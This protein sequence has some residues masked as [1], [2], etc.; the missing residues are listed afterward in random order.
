MIRFFIAILFNFKRGPSIVPAMRKMI[1]HKDKYPEK[2]RYALALRLIRYL[3]KSARITT[4]VYGTENLP[5]SGG[6][7]MYPNHQGKY[8]AL[9]IMYAHR[10]PCTFVMDKAK[11][12]GFLVREMVDLLGAKRL[13]L[14]DVRQNIRIMDQIEKEVLEGKRFILFSEG[15]YA[16]NGNIVQRFKPGSFKCAMRAK[17]PIIPVTLIDSYLAFNSFKPGPV[18]TKVIFGRPIFYETYKDMKTHEIA[19]MVRNTIIST[20]E[21]FGVYVNNPENNPDI[22]QDI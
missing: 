12:Y 11:S 16:H 22:L 17:V 9:G 2:S 14:D 13:A 15:G 3:K 8:D 19:D 6:Y 1:K 18:T 20:M 5:E 10:E 21:E 7:I 4:E